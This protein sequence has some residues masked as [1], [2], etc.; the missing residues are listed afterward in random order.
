MKKF[1]VSAIVIIMAITFCNI[2][3]FAEDNI[4][5]IIDGDVIE[6]DVQPQIINGRTMV[7]FRRIFEVLGAEVNYQFGDFNKTYGVE[8]C[9]GDLRVSFFFGEGA[10]NPNEMLITNAKGVISERV[11]LDVA[12]MIIDGRTL[13]PLRAVS[14]GLNAEVDWDGETSTVYITT[15]YSEKNSEVNQEFDDKHIIT[16]YNKNEYFDFK[17]KNDKVKITG[18]TNNPKIKYL[19]I[20]LENEVENKNDNNFFNGKVKVTQGK[21]FHCEIDLDK[22]FRNDICEITIFN[23]PEEYGTF[24]GYIY[25]VLKIEKS[26][27]DYSFIKPLVYDSSNAVV[28]EWV[29]PIGYLKESKYSELITLSNEICNGAE[30]DYEK[31]LRIHDWVAENIYYDYD[32][33]YSSLGSTFFDADKVYENKRTVCEGYANLMRELIQIQ[34]IPCRKIVG[35]ALGISSKNKYWTNDTASITDSNHAWVQ[36]F[37]DNRWVNIDVTWDSGNEYRSGQYIYNGIKNHR[38]FDISDEF[39]AYNHKNLYIEV[40]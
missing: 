39:L 32:A 40:D 30:D 23:G 3:V 10:K 1:L 24:Q 26:N 34:N 14:E 11:E 17:I 29:N 16:S 21:E 33:Y 20:R 5:V 4:T 37:V 28:S 7:P 19:W 18:V 13:V 36:A 38:Y 22:Y 2:S 15:Q 25:D 27:G 6:F 31:I 35:Y 9:I 12:P 8:G